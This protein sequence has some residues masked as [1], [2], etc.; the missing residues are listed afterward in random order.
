MLLLKF[1]DS[2]IA[3]ETLSLF[4]LVPPFFIIMSLF[5][6][7]LVVVTN[8]LFFISVFLVPSGLR[9]YSRFTLCKRCQLS[10]PTQFLMRSQTSN[11]WPLYVTYCF[12]QAALK[13]FFFFDFQQFDSVTPNVILFIFI[14]H[15]VFGFL[16]MKICLLQI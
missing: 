3:N 10:H 14:L 6:V 5:F 11:C 8:T 9:Q 12:S 7:L 13:I 1:L 4:A 15:R 2:N 16:I